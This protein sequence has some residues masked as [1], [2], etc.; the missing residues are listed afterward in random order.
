MSVPTIRVFSIGGGGG[1]TLL[2][3]LKDARA[4]RAPKDTAATFGVVDSP[5]D[6]A[7]QTWPSK[8]ESGLRSLLFNPMMSVLNTC[9]AG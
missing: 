8:P 3:A 6:L 7:V 1:V 2:G 4:D 9:S 5:G